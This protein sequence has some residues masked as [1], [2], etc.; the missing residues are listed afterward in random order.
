MDGLHHEGEGRVHDGAGLFG[1]EVFDERH[2][3]FD[4][5][6]QGGNGFALA[7]RNGAGFHRRLLGPD[8]FGEMI[9]RVDYWGLGIRG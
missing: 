7:V 2:G 5:S 9:R 8:P 3:A 1:I 6:K 4:V